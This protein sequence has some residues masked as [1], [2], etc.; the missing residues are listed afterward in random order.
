MNYL[1][2]VFA[3]GRCVKDIR[4][5]GYM[6]SYN[7]AVSVGDVSIAPGDVVFGDTNGIVVIPREHF[8]SVYEELDKAYHEE[9]LT[10]QGL[11]GGGSAAELFAEHKRF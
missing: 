5:R 7:V 11:Q 6:H 3:T 8:A 9:Q 4:R 1:S 2:P 10:Q